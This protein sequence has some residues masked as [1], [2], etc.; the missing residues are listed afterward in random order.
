M[1]S[2]SGRAGDIGSLPCSSLFT[3]CTNCSGLKEATEAEEDEGIKVMLQT[4]QYAT[5]ISWLTYP[6][7][8]ILPMLGLKGASLVVGIQVGYC[9]SDVISKC[10]VG[11]VI[12]TITIAKSELLNGNYDQGGYQGLSAEGQ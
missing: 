11:L 8:Y 1:K 12:Y 9:I 10:G 2:T 7:V 6:I 3:L 5:V 4:A